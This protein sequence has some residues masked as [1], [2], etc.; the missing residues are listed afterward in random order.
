MAILAFVGC[1][2]TGKSTLFQ[3][4]LK[5]TNKHIC[6]DRFAACQFVYGTLHGKGAPKLEHLRGI[7]R[8]MAK[9]G[10]IY[11]HVTADTEDIIERFKKHKEKDIKLEEIETVKSKYEHYLEHSNMP[12]YTIN[13]SVFGIEKCVD[14]ILTF[15][16]FEEDEIL[17]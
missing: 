5:R 4:V 8:Q 15:A 3:E 12:V 17:W 7:E 2:K 6:I 13:T 1:D 14:D 10:G 9:V 16:E 11:I